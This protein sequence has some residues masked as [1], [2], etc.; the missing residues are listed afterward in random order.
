MVASDGTSLGQFSSFELTRFQIALG[1][2]TR[3]A[4]EKEYNWGTLGWIPNIP[5]DKSHG[6]RAFVDSGHADSTRYGAQLD[7][8]EGL[9]GVTGDIHQAQDLH[10]ML[11]F[12][13]K[14]LKEF[15]FGFAKFQICRNLDS[16]PDPQD[17]HRNRSRSLP[18]PQ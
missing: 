16:K 13:L 7:H 9:I 12:V 17:I 18:L 6:R 4:R 10:H 1:I 3:K 15:V 14:G 5:S 8:D 11:S 2:L